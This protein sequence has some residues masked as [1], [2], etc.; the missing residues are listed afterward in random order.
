MKAK[1][2]KLLKEMTQIYEQN[3]ALDKTNKKL[4][5]DLKDQFDKEKK[6]LVALQKQSKPIPTAPQNNT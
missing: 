6:L 1:E 4:R 3:K 2:D 5:L